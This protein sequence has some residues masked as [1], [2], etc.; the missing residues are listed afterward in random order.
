M[1]QIAQNYKS[2]ELSLLDVPVPSCQPGGVVVRTAYSVI[3]TGTEMM[4]ISE[5]KRSLLGKA[6]ARPDQV[7]KVINAARQQGLK[8]T[9][10]K[11]MNRLDSYTPLG[12]SLAG[13]V[14][15]V[16]GGVEE[17]RVG[18]AVA[19]AGNQFAFH[20]QYNWVPERMCVPI[21]LGVNL[22]QAAFTTIGAIALHG[23]RQGDV[24]LGETAC[25]IG[26]GLLGQILVRLLRGAG[27]SVVGIDMVS[28]RCQL[29]EAAGASIC[30]VPAAPDFDRFLRE[31]S[32]LTG[33]HGID[34]IFITAG[35]DSND[36]VELAAKLA[37]DRA[38]VIEIGKC[39]LDLPWNA[40][41]EKELDVRFSRSYGPGRY[42]PIYEQ[43][44][45]DYPIGYVR[46]TERRN[47]ECILALLSEGRLDLSPLITDVFPFESAVE[48]YEGMSKGKLSGMGVVFEY[49]KE[50]PIARSVAICTSPRK[51][52][53]KVNL[54]VIGAGNYVSSMLL[55]HL[56][57]DS[58]V[59]LACVV[60]NTALSAANAA[61][62]FAFAR[63]STDS[64]ELFAADDIDAILI[65]TRHATHARLVCSALRSG[66][67]VFVE[68]PLAITRESLSDISRTI[69]KTGNDRLMVG[70]NRRFSPL[71]LQMK[72]SWGKR[73]GQEVIYYRINA[74]SLEKG[75]WYSQSET[76]GSRFV[77][78]G[79]HF[80]DTA[81]WWF[82][83]EP[84]QIMAA[85]TSGNP[86]NLTATLTYP[87][88]SL[89]II[90]Y[91]TDGDPSIPKEH[92]EIFGGGRVA[93][94]DNFTGFEIWG[95]GRSKRTRA[96]GVDKGQKAALRAFISAI[97][98][99]NAM[100]IDVKSLLA[101][102]VATIAAQESVAANT[103]I[104]L[105]V[106][107]DGRIDATDW[108]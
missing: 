69:K 14:A 106:D 34:C 17:L 43:A 32:L 98:T 81:S 47:M 15:E 82:E 103:P 57:D 44:G 50:V 12:Y 91:L 56:V 105:A 52:S 79:G 101:T 78:E 84:L 87:D 100:P 3:S 90:S 29:A 92:V 76:E 24:R 27:V 18:Q 95:S 16:G 53:G 20:A 28:T 61:K 60:T 49:Q 58:D 25:V 22:D 86:D 39:K 97:R 7:K 108:R 62:K 89:C 48:V 38:R 96:R 13:V 2:G 11:V 8:A 107:T 1:K 67:A 4:K 93:R 9:F 37:R 72:N 42:D 30:A 46:W 102:S 99:G 65:G 68:K 19:C 70:F 36:P 10:Q 33:G 31:V 64:D 77:G 54:G 88:G 59:V 94:F 5:S 35:G 6:R 63:S 51:T 45:I 85:A 41:Y 23:M 40:Y 80:I 55:P 75:S 73:V 26:L 21:P 71:L 104:R 74:G 66:K 83:E